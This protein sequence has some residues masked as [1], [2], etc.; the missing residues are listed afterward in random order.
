MSRKAFA[1]KS[2]WKTP[3]V[4][5]FV[6][7][8]GPFRTRQHDS[9]EDVVVLLYKGNGEQVRRH[10]MYGLAKEAQHVLLKYQDDT[11]GTWKYIALDR[12]TWLELENDYLCY[13]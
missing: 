3:S 11:T 9:I 7:G 12:G 1:D 4:Y 5:A 10:P 2:S 6:G 8:Y 13:C